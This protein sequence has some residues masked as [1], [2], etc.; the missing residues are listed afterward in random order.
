VAALAIDEDVDVL[1][2]ED[3]AAGVR[4]ASGSE[5][6]IFASVIF[7]SMR[8]R[9]SSAVSHSAFFSNTP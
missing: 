3:F 8:C 9:T 6:G 2:A 5:R 4:R 7:A 1:V